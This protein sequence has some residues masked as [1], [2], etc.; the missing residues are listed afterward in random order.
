LSKERAVNSEN[1]DSLV[2]GVANIHHVQEYMH[3][4]FVCVW[5]GGC[6]V[7]QVCMRA[8]ILFHFFYCM[9]IVFAHILFQK[10]TKVIN[11]VVLNPETKGPQ[12]LGNNTV[13]KEFMHH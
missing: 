3:S 8:L 6:G 13:A 7:R 11:P 4:L 5:V 12:I 10:P 1:K 9:Q 2:L